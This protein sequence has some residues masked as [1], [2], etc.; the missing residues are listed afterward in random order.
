MKK[1]GGRLY[2]VFCPRNSVIE[3]PLCRCAFRDERA[4]TLLEIIIVIALLGSLMVYLVSNLT[5][6][7]D[8]AKEDQA[9]LAM[10][11]I[12]Q[13]LQMYR[14][15]NNRYPTVDQGLDALLRNPGSARTWRG[16]YIEADKLNDPWGSPFSY[17]IDGRNFRLISPGFDGV[18][19]NEDD[20]SYPDQQGAA[21]PE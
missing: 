21:E 6:V 7:G 14:V 8:A 13:A 5:S 1:W 18:V 20:I 4:L 12:A 10:G 9:R 19:G 2:M 17:E 11:G 15:H 3:K 16:P